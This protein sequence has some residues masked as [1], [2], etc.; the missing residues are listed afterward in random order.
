MRIRIRRV[1]FFFLDFVHS[2]VE[3]V[4]PNHGTP[5]LPLVEDGVA[6]H[7]GMQIVRSG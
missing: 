2:A 7:Y 1:F 5:K 4:L 6:S 3:G